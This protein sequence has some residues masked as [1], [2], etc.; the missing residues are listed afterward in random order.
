MLS[1][2]AILALAAAT[3]VGCEHAPAGDPRPT[4]VA[5]AFFDALK[6]SDWDSAASLADSEWLVTYRA[7]QI[8][9]IEAVVI[10]TKGLGGLAVG[11]ESGSVPADTFSARLLRQYG[12][13]PVHGFPGVATL[14]DL[15]RLSP[16]AFLS[17]CFAG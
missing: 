14:A 5:R 8:R 15:E 7:R 3:I 2:R 1:Q 9:I 12:S 16:R 4:Q 10:A 11:R 6:R 17:Q 13:K